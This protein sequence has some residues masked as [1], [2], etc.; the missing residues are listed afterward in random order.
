MLQQEQNYGAVFTRR[1]VVELML[2]ECGYNKD[3]DLGALVAVEPS[4]GDGA[5]LLPMVAR[6]SQSLRKH[7]RD[8]ASATNAIRA[9]DLQLKHVVAC[10]GA[11]AE[12]LEQDGWT[13]AA[14][15]KVAKSWIRH[16]DYLLDDEEVQ[17]TWV[18]GNPPYIR[19][20][21]IEASLRSRYVE[22]CQTMTVGADIFVGFIEKGLRSLQP[23][24]SLCFIVADRWMHN[25][26]GKKL[27]GMVAAGFD[28]SVVYELHDVDAF[29]EVV[30]AYP[31]ITMIR[32]AP[33]GSVRFA[34]ASPEFDE[35]AA[36]RLLRWSQNKNPAPLADPSF[37]AAI[38]PTWFGTDEVWASASPE[39][40]ALIE[41]LNNRLPLIERSAPGTKIGIG[42][43]TGA[44][45]I[46]IQRGKPDLEDDRLVSLVLTD[47]T[48]SGVVKW[49]EAWLVNPW[50]DDGSL[51]ELNTYPKLQSYLDKYRSA[52]TARHIAR[53]NDAAWYRTIDK[54]HPGLQRAPKLLIP[55]M[56]ATIQPVFDD[57]HYP[58]HNLYWII[59]SGWDLEVLGGLL[60][61]K[62]AEM[63]VSAYGVKMRGGTLRFQA[64]YL[65]KIRVPEPS[66]I[67]PELAERLVEAFRSRDCEAATVAAMEAYGIREL[68]E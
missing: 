35:N 46:F 29:A 11:V 41:T 32:N 64:Q 62:V 48:Q 13:P 56:K 52:L 49:D 53:K 50:G 18:I 43:A 39:R 20:T 4:C 1:W 42:I 51:V 45:K 54:V 17:A 14:S 34:V 8:L 60:L 6:L 27:R 63:F 3:E 16:Q 15:K 7:G 12:L 23:G 33:Q 68:P 38:L 9:Y 31:A 36:R 55:D 66:T 26:Y 21:N 19:S 28:V 57:R 37:K 30:S 65:R 5:F 44:D 67:S 47:H 25:S 58:H 22:R 2:D 40:L 61:S 59:S 24:G 10:R